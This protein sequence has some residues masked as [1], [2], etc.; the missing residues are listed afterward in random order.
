MFPALLSRPRHGYWLVLGAAI[1]GLVVFGLWSLR[2]TTFYVDEVNLFQS[3]RGFGPA[4]L[5]API[6]GHLIAIPR[7]IYAASFG[8][9]GAAYLPFRLVELIGVSVV[10]VLFFVLAERRVGGWVALAP[11]MLLLFFGTSWEITVSPLGI[12]NVYAL[13]AGLA[14]FLALEQ[15]SRR[16]DVLAASF[17]VIAIATYSTGLAFVAGATVIVLLGK[18]RWRRVWVVAVPLALYGAW[19]LMKP[20]LE[21]S[22]S[23]VTELSFQISDLVSVPVFALESAA[24]VAAAATGL[25]LESGGSLIPND[26]DT[27]WAPAGALVACVV[28]AAVAVR[29]TRGNVAP[30]LW[31]ALA[32]TLALWTLFSLGSSAGALPEEARSADELRYLYPGAV[33]A[34]LVMVE[35]GA[36]IRLSRA[37]VAVLYGVL[38][39]AMVVNLSHMREGA[40]FLREYSAM[41]RA[42]FTALTLDP[43]PIQH[44]SDSDSGIG[45]LLGVDPV[46]FQH[47]VARTGSPG[48]ALEGLPSESESTRRRV[49]TAVADV[50][51]VGLRRSKTDEVVTDG[52]RDRIGT[53]STT[54]RPPGAWLV[55][56]TS[57]PVMVGRFSSVPSLVIGRLSVGE[58]TFL[59]VPADRSRIPWRVKAPQATSLSI[60]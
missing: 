29:L 44:K 56:E 19:W 4:S 16:A 11:S 48:F 58:P 20:S 42:H 18:D 5:A 45:F 41:A 24:A 34:L 39:V 8:L 43:S 2:G 32:T 9:F 26:F 30:T 57:T 36:G 12:P 27:P 10:A 22:L 38:T 35:A 53:A 6:N 7:V 15:R 54:V 49:D 17:L 46:R 28:G 59:R 47:A 40:S 21:T 52:C 14:A 25:N 3:D 37:G 23:G 33:A 31:G 60:C 55:S 13:A 50:V 1:L 51:G